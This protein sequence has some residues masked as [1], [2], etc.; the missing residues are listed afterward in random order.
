MRKA[1]GEGAAGFQFSS[2]LF[3]EEQ[4]ERVLRCIPQRASHQ[5]AQNQRRIL[6]VAGK[7]IC[8]EVFTVTNGL[9]F[10]FWMISVALESAF[11]RRLTVVRRLLAVGQIRFGALLLFGEQRFP[12]A[13]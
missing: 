3:T 7:G 9:T 5:R 11:A 8:E 4:R 12:I 6:L 1:A 10:V 13:P 2:G